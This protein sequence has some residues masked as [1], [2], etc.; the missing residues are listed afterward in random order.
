MSVIVVNNFC[1]S[2][3]KIRLFDSKSID[4][5]I[6]LDQY[7]S[8]SFN[9]FEPGYEDPII[10]ITDSKISKSSE[11]QG[12]PKNIINIQFKKDDFRGLIPNPYR[13]DRVR[14]YRLLAKDEDGNNI[15]LQQDCFYIENN[16]MGR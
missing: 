2:I 12:Y 15:L 8:F 16:L 1:D 5:Q 6:D 4:Q 13:S 7:S 10:S 9:V 3:E 14:E 11:Y